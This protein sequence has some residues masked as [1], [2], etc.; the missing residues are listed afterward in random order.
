MFYT[1]I[2]ARKSFET[3][4]F[5]TERRCQV[6]FAPLCVKS[7]TRYSVVGIV[8]MLRTGWSGAWIPIEERDFAVL[9]NGS[10]DHPSSYSVGWC[11]RDVKWTTHR[12]LVPKS[13]I[14][15]D[16]TIFFM[17]QQPLVGQ[18]LL[19][20]EVS[21]SHF[22]HTTLGRTPLDNWSARR[23]DLYLTTYNTH[24]R[25]TSMSPTRFEPAIL[26]SER[27]Q[28]HAERAATGIG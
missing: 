25:Q 9:Q 7:G 26:A 14:S 11:G 20:A 21:R 22:R 4:C 8:T 2:V 19:I 27:P 15:R 5:R 28:A 12:R 17:P 18:G 23:R 1:C 10:E 24:K 13:S 16:L 6:T 3:P